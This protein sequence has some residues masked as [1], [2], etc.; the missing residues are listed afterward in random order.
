[1]VYTIHDITHKH[2]ITVAVPFALES[3]KNLNSNQLLPKKLQINSKY[4]KNLNRKSSMF[5]P[6]IC[7]KI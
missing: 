7:F 2:T 3:D 5:S 1:M 6:Y 4:D